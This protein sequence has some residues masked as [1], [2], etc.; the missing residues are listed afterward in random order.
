MED[1]KKENNSDKPNAVQVKKE[2]IKEFVFSFFIAALIAIV[3]RSFLYEPFYIP[4]GSMKSTLLEGDYVFVSKYTYGYS[5]YSLP[6]GINVIEGR[7]F[8]SEP[9]RG[10]VV[11]FKLPKDNSTNY[12]KRLIGMPGDEIQVINGHLHINGKPTIIK[13]AQDFVDTDRFGN[14]IVMSSYIETLPNGV[15]YRILDQYEK[16]P[17]DNTE[18][19]KVPENSYFFM[20]DNRDNS[21][22]SRVLSEVGYV[23]KINLLG[24]AR[25][26]FFSS[27]SSLMQFWNWFSG[28]RMDRFF[29]VINDE[30]N[31][32]S[33]KSNS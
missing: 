17:L 5:R 6:F 8:Q 33:I 21:Q 28:I 1:I 11:V 23:P 32:E 25:I 22:D 13:K 15:S 3:F 26:I 2:G 27:T 9:N 29:R 7:V 20:G 4:S 18:V 16:G 12:I 30:A 10:D 19:Y 14:K 24:P 31:L